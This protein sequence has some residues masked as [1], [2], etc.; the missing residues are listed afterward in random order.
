MGLLLGY[1]TVS[2][3]L[4]K[5]EALEAEFGIPFSN[6][7]TGVQTHEMFL[8]ANYDI[9]VFRGVNFQPEFEYVIR[10]N[11]QANIHNA[12]VFGFKTHVEF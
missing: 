4:G 2:G 8:E 10:P 3:V 7:A 12:A 9:H 5:V 1:N 6:Q 11:A